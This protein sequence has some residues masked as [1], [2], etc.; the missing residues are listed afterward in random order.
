[1]KLRHFYDKTHFCISMSSVTWTTFLAPHYLVCPQRLWIDSTTRAVLHRSLVLLALSR[2]PRSGWRNCCAQYICYPDNFAHLSSNLRVL[3]KITRR[4]AWAAL[5]NGTLASR[6]PQ[7]SKTS[8][9]FQLSPAIEELNALYRASYPGN[10]FE[11]RMLE[12]GY[13]YGIRRS[14]SRCSGAR[15]L[16]VTR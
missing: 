16:N 13:Y 10:W 4:R 12:T 11:P 8:D 2:E 7:R 15:L 6:E 3:M 1:M 14:V 9:T 5:Q